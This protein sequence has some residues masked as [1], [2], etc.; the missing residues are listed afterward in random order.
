MSAVSITFFTPTGSPW[1]G[2][3]GSSSSRVRAS[4][5]AS[6]GSMCAHAR[7]SPSRSAM[8]ARHS[9][10]SSSELTSRSAT[11]RAASVALTMAAA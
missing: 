9:R 7:S 2:P 6:S 8:R 1:S 11:S 5:I 4:A 3:R 10:A